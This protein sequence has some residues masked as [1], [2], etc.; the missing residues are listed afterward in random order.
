MNR[1]LYSVDD[2][3]QLLKLQ[4]QLITSTLTDKNAD[5]ENI[6]AQCVEYSSKLGLQ[7]GHCSKFKKC[8]GYYLNS[9]K[10]GVDI[11]DVYKSYQSIVVAAHMIYASIMKK[12]NIF[13]CC[14]KQMKYKDV[15]YVIYPKWIPGTLTNRKYV[16]N[17]YGEN[18]IFNIHLI[19]SM[20]VSAYPIISREIMLATNKAIKLISLVDTNIRVD[21]HSSRIRTIMMNDESNYCSTVF[22]HLID[23]CVNF[24]HNMLIN[25]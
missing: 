17:S 12:E 22:Y 2:L 13:I 4:T 16:I 23:T 24:A 11:I 6:I 25:K 19:I 3:T 10:Y 18:K 1:T 15:N 21:V 20:N 8:H 5:V 9:I 14:N 7:Y